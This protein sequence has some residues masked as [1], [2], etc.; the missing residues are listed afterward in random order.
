MTNCPAIVHIMTDPQY[1]IPTKL[2]WG[3]YRPNA[4]GV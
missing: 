3:Q 4:T 1:G 2:P